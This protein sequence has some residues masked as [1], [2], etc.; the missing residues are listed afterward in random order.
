MNKNV[1]LIVIVLGVLC[2]VGVF[3]LAFN[4]QDSSIV[5]VSIKPENANEDMR[6]DADDVMQNLPAAAKVSDSDSKENSAP[7]NIV[8]SGDYRFDGRIIRDISE[9][10]NRKLEIVVGANH[11]SPSLS[12][13][14]TADFDTTKIIRT[15]EV[16]KTYRFTVTYDSNAKT[17]T[18]K[19]MG[20]IIP[21]EQ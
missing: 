14:I 20:V 17:Y 11:S 5:Q 19:T 8:L 1:G 13:N 4:I 9:E 2:G 16:G 12:G 18:V 7:E 3:Y 21:G 10:G 15:P 6:L